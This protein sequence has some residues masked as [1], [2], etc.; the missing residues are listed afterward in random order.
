MEHLDTNTLATIILTAPRWVQTNLAAPG[1][2]CRQRAAE[3]LART[4]LERT[5]RNVTP[6]P[7]PNQLG[8]GL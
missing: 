3:E 1:E 4:I 7:N 5:E 6:S 2:R 8:L